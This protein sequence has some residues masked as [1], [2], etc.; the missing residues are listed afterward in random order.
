HHRQK[1][2][3]QL[4]PHVFSPFGEQLD[5]QCICVSQS[6]YKYVLGAMK[7]LCQK[8]F[9][10]CAISAGMGMRAEFNGPGIAAAGSQNKRYAET[11]R[12]LEDHAI[13]LDQSL[14]RETK[15]AK[16]IGSQRIDARLIEHNA[17]TQ[18]ECGGKHFIQAMK[19]CLI[20]NAIGQGH[21][22]AAL[23]FAEGEIAFTVHGEREDVRIVF[24]NLRGAVTLVDIKIDHG[25]APDESALPQKLDGHGNV[26]EYA[27]ACP[28]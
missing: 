3:S 16:R 17:R 23:L 25:G 19:I 24:K 6:S 18:A 5:C 28:F 20:L 13:T 2:P 27:K 26:I 22:E 14:R 21:I 4:Y 9:P 10:C 12:G 1:Q 8:H 11:A 7:L 15:A